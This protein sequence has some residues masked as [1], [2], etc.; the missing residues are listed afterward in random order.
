LARIAGHSSITITQRYCNPQAD[1]IERAFK[2]IG[3]HN[4][5]HSSDYRNLERIGNKL[6]KTSV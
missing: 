3:R 1:A 4:F 6:L 5:G 2:K